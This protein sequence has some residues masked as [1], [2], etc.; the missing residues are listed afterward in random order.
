[1]EGEDMDEVGSGS[2]QQQTASV[3][4]KQTEV[5]SV[6]ESTAAEAEASVEKVR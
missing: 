6:Q 2:E 4:L 3:E 1:M 5:I